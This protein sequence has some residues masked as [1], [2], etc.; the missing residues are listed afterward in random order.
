MDQIEGQEA[1]DGSR[2]CRID[3]LLLAKSMRIQAR[4]VPYVPARTPLRKPGCFGEVCPL[5][6][7][8]VD[9]AEPFRPLD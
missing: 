9:L 8:P 4:S 5:L 1:L 2:G 7:W 3:S 6:G